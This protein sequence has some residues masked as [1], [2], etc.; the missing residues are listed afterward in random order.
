MLTD[1]T[2][3]FVAAERK[4]A[5]DAKRLL[6]EVP[7]C[8]LVGQTETNDN[9]VT[10]VS[11]LQPNV[12]LIQHNMPDLNAVQTIS[13]IRKTAN[14]VKILML[15]SDEVDI[16]SALESNADG[17]ALWPTTLL[18]TAIDVVAHGGVW[19]GPL[20]TE[21]LLRGP[22]FSTLRSCA[23]TLTSIPPLFQLLSDREREVLNLLLEGLTNQQIATSLNLSVGTVK[24]HV[25]HI[26]GKLKLEHRGEAIVKLTRLRAD[27]LSPSV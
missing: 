27:T 25:R 15:L 26:L 14:Q 12:I 23:H 8:H 19:L 21:Y 3:V 2:K 18:P 16:W 13:E 5:E 9:L 20:I 10:M 1:R 11:A 7:G 22:G 17:Y 24:V 6:G 4:I